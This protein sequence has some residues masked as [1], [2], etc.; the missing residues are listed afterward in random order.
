MDSRRKLLDIRK[1]AARRA[2]RAGNSGNLLEVD[3]AIP[4]RAWRLLHGFIITRYS[5]A[6]RSH[7]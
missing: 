5:E 6:R 1:R 2:A 3:D 7:E 4:A